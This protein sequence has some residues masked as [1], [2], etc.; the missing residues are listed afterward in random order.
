[1]LLRTQVSERSYTPTCAMLFQTIRQ[2]AA[3]IDC[4]EPLVNPA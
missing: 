4:Q 1:M 3:V 2:L